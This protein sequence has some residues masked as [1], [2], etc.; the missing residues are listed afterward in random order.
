MEQ[1]VDRQDGYAVVIKAG[2]ITK[3]GTV[4]I[5]NSDWIEKST[6]EEYQLLP[7]HSNIIVERYDVLVVSTGDGSLGKAGV[8]E[9][10]TPAIV[11]GHVAIIRTNRKETDPYYVAD[12]LRKGA[13]AIQINRAYTGAT[14][15][16]ELTPAQL[17]TIMIDTLD[18]DI[19]KQKEASKRLRK[20]EQQALKYYQKAEETIEDTNKLFFLETVNIE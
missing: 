13:G 7:N 2:N 18:G 4:D 19:K 5:D 11:D 16:I 6:Y 17:D 3:Y 9:L 12:Y 10:N 8:Y 15:M 1:Y 14:G 20:M